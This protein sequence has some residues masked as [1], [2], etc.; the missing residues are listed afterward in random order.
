M[1]QD[2]RK[3]LR[4]PQR[5]RA[6]TNPVS[7]VSLRNLAGPW[8][9][10]AALIGACASFAFVAFGAKPRANVYLTPF[11][12]LTVGQVLTY[13]IAYHTDKSAKTKSTV[14]TSTP[15]LPSGTETNV[16]ALLRLE[17]EGVERQGQ[18]ATIHA[19]SYFQTMNSGTRLTVPR[20]LPTPPDQVQRQDP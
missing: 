8:L 10:S 20:D 19:R 7:M 11:P 17:V 18:R 12:K 4:Q 1:N 16:R 6:P 5:R 9:T 3:R 13:Q 14:A 15:Q 2:I